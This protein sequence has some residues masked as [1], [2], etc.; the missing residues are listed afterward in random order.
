MLTYR[1]FSESHFLESI[2][3]RDVVPIKRDSEREERSEN[4]L[5]RMV[6][7]CYSKRSVCLHLALKGKQ[8]REDV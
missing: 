4:R 2:A 3:K 6:N 8:Q 1:L 5:W 7:I